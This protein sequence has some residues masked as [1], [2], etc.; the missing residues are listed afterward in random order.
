MVL[1]NKSAKKFKNR[2]TNNKKR[3]KRVNRNY[4]LRQ[5]LQKAGAASTEGEEPGRTEG[6][7]PGRRRC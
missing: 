4:R 6:E 3:S 7:E 1:Q 5:L 2:S